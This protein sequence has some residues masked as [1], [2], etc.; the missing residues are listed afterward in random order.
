M[1]IIVGLG[2]PG[3]K[4][5]RT[6]HNLGFMTA[7]AAA[8]K[9]GVKLK[10]RECSCLTAVFSRGGE[11]SVLA[12]PQTYMNLSGDAVKSLIKKYGAR[13]GDVLVVFDE[14]DLDPCALR[15]RPS[16]SGGSH[17]GM[18]HIVAALGT[19]N[20][21]RLRIGIGRPDGEKP[22]HDHVLSDIPP[23]SREPMFQAILKAA[24]ACVDFLRGEPVEGLMIKYNG[25]NK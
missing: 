3:D 12:T 4:Y 20:I 11:R 6:Y 21:P 15:L 5:L 19:E 22:L 8:Q 24:D 25:T 9:L 16:G 13:P 17:N 18:S 10:K 23:H 2:N 1:R 7:E 14:A